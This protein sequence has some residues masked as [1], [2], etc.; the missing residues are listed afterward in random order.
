MPILFTSGYSAGAAYRDG[1]LPPGVSFLHKP[2][3]LA[4]LLTAVRAL[5]DAPAQESGAGRP[6]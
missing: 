6:R 3:T 1:D 5:L 4:D 2:W